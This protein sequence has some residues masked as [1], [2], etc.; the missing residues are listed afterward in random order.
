MDGGQINALII[1]AIGLDVGEALGLMLT[2]K[3]EGAEHPPCRSSVS[4]AGLR[5]QQGVMQAQALVL[6]TTDSTI[7]GKGEID[8]GKET[9]ALELLA[10]PKD[11]SVLTAS[12]PVRIEGTFKHPKIGVVSKELEEQEPGGLWRSASCCRWSPARSCRSSSRAR[13]R[14]PTAAS[15]W[16]PHRPYP[17]AAFADLQRERRRAAAASAR[18][19]RR[20]P[21]SPCRRKRSWRDDCR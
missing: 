21:A 1:E 8:L 14:A 12:T 7:T 17:P 11:A 13:P 19:S 15:C 10:H 9:L 4:S 6:D 2:Q 5:V 20:W 3:H 16:R 18:H